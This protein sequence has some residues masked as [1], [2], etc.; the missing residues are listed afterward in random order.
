MSVSHI[1]IDISKKSFNAALRLLNGKYRDKKFDNNQRG[2][3]ELL[4]WIQRHAEGPAHVCME[5]T[6]VYWE[7]CAEALFQARIVVS[8]INPALAN[9][10]ARSQGLRNKT[11]AVDAR[12]LAEFCRQKEPAPWQPPSPAH[13]QLKALVLRHQALVEMKTQETNRVEVSREAVQ[14]S[15]QAHVNWLEEE[16]KRI[17]ALIQQSID[18]DPD[19]RIQNELLISIPG[20]GDRTSSTLLAFGIGEGRFQSAAQFASYAGLTPRHHESGTSIRGKPRMSKIGHGR[21]RSAVYMPALS[22]LH[23]TKWGKVFLDRL[24]ANGKSPKLIVGAMMRKLVQVA[25]GVIKSG[26][27][28]DPALHGA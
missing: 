18:D 25:F 10:H 27:P 2:I 17:E 3:N 16:L 22:S 20:I 26:R 13:R 28:F 12:A 14:P 4:D 11:D 7:A 1:G 6:G 8:V 21:I 23:R 24:A 19:L 5:A 15:L 9:A